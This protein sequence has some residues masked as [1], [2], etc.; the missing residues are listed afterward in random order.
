MARKMVITSGKGGVGKTTIC[1]SLGSLLAQN[2]YKVALLDFDIGLNNLDVLL[3]VES[4]VGFDIFDVIKGSCRVRQALIQI[5]ANP[6][7]YLMPSN[8]NCS[9][10]SK[11]EI[12][13]V[14][15][16]LDEFYDYILI[17]CPAG[18]EDGFE[19]AVCVA[20]EV[21]IVVN[22][23]IASLRDASKV[24]SLL[25]SYSQEN[26][27]CVVNRVRG[28]L[29]LEKKLLS[30]EDI[31]SLLN[32]NIL[33]VLPED[34]ALSYLTGIALDKHLKLSRPHAIILENLIDGTN[35][36][37]D[38]TAKY[39]GFMGLIKRKIKRSV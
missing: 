11:A 16:E 10:I 17:D 7:L 5:D 37:Y 20:D 4:Q 31:Y 32:I 12:K 24:L 15:K 19:R 14:V 26:C 18:I 8:S 1:V 38:C 29:L 34:D 13:K 27:S 39:R 2:G 21:V 22:A 35:K 23:T 36:I 3:E 33:G 6:Y 25:H 9:K 30:I 28:D